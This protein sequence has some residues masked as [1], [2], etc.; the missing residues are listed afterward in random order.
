MADKEILE[1]A[2]QQTI[3]RGFVLPFGATYFA[4]DDDTIQFFD[5]DREFICSTHVYAIIFDPEF[6]KALWGESLIM[7]F[8][9]NEGG[10]SDDHGYGWD[11]LALFQYQLQQMVILPT[12]R[13]R[14]KYLGENI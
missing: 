11:T 7:C 8:D 5:D 9:C 3:E 1:K 4:V 12:P 2:I 14:I 6:A 10:H 13:E